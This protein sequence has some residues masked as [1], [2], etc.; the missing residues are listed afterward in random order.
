MEHWKPIT[1]Y[2][3]FYEVSN[4]GN[5]RSVPRKILVKRGEISFFMPSGGKVLKPQKT[6]HGYVCVWLYGK[7]WTGNRQGKLYSIHRLVAKEFCDNPNGY[8]EVNHKNEIKWDNR[9]ENLEWCTHK[10]NT[11]YGTAQERRAAKRSYVVDQFDLNGKYIATY[12]S[13]CEAA[14]QTGVTYSNI[15]N[16]LTGKYKQAKGFIWKRTPLTE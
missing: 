14:R 12:K 6:T 7:E 2:E 16:C 10:E 13:M 9:A 4:L 5:V 15:N 1:G 8:N 3:G 11:N